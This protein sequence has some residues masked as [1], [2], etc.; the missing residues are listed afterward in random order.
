MTI[1]RALTSAALIA[2]V[3]A[4]G[5]SPAAAQPC[6]PA[7]PGVPRTLFER[8][9]IVMSAQMAATRDGGAV[10]AFSSYDGTPEFPDANFTVL[11]L[12]SSGC[13]RWRASLRG[14]FLA[15]P[16]QPDARSIVVASGTISGEP[17]RIYTLSARTGG[18]LRTDVFRSLNAIGTTLL[19][20]RRGNLAVTLASAGESPQT[21]K[22]TRRAGSTRWARQVINDSNIQAPAAN[23]RPSGEM[24]VGYPRRGRFLIRTGTVAGAL[25]RPADAGPVTGNF[26]PSAVAL[27]RDGSIAAVWQSV[28]YNAP[29]RL[30]AAVRPPGAR[31][32]SRFAQLGF[33]GAGSFLGATPPA[34]RV[35]AG[36]RV[37]IGFATGEAFMCAN[38]TRA[39]RFGRPR[40]IAAGGVADSDLPAM[41]FEPAGSGTIVASTSGGTGLLRVG[42]GCD[43]R[44][45]E[46]LDP[47]AGMPQQAAIDAR[48]RTWVLGQP[49]RV[50][51]VGVP[52]DLRLTIVG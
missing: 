30:R 27:G 25:G 13:A 28:T 8:V 47:G 44:G 40:R 39:G 35:G 23:A 26:K 7:R 17:L 32:F 10:I 4:I 34:V 15:R 21:L 16:I 5:A 12:D 49:R 45:Q 31:R 48:G 18:V 33:G 19:A 1:R 52:E 24:V 2:A 22:L 41:M 14:Q 29:W 46:P 37:V 20:D 50:A 36:G 11:A 38:A 6:E 51:D 43:P 42:A 9:P 3:S